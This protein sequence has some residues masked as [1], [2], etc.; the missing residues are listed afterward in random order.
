MY[1]SKSQYYCHL[2]NKHGYWKSCWKWWFSMSMFVYQMVRYYISDYTIRITIL[3]IYTLQVCVV[4]SFACQAN[5]PSRSKLRYCITWALSQ[6][7]I[8]TEAPNLLRLFRHRCLLIH[9]H[10]KRL[11]DPWCKPTLWPCSNALIWMS[12]N[13]LHVIWMSAKIL[14]WRVWGFLLLS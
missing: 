14:I 10:R 7:D 3:C 11:K 5:L 4:M 13:H 1:V 9:L 2:A 12:P 6:G 8:Q